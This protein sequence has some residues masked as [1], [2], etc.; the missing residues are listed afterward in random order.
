MSRERSCWIVR[1]SRW[2]V[3]LLLSP[4]SLLSRIWLPA[5]RRLWPSRTHLLHVM[6][7]HHRVLST[8]VTAGQGSLPK[9]SFTE[10]PLPLL[11]LPFSHHLHLPLLALTL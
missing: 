10:L 3:L 4:G 6:F 7:L 1:G 8:G 5:K 2:L 11:H 9:L